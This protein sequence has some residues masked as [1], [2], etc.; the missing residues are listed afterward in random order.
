MLGRIPQ[1]LVCLTAVAALSA[2]ATSYACDIDAW[3]PYEPAGFAY[4]DR[5]AEAT[6]TLTPTDTHSWEDGVS[7]SWDREALAWMAETLRPY[8]ERLDSSLPSYAW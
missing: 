3:C 4:A 7:Y 2:P 5:H 8:S 1:L 6:P